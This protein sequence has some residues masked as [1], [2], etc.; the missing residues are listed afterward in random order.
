MKK[1][2]NILALLLAAAM[3]LSLAACGKDGES[4]GKAEA[5]P[6]PE[7]VYSSEFKTLA[8]GPQG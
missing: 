2:R 3:L 4:G 1:I 6:T 7:Y 8:Q 5:T